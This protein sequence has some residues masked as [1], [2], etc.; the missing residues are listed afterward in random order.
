MSQ[1]NSLHTQLTNTSCLLGQTGPRV[2]RRD[3]FN[4]SV[5]L[6]PRGSHSGA[7][8]P[9][10]GPTTLNSLV[11]WNC[12]RKCS[13]HPNILM[14][15]TLSCAIE[16]QLDTEGVNSTRSARKLDVLVPSF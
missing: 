15:S 9:L 11:G 10:W 7:S 2:S 6:G 12:W 14:G 13:D 1:G 4:L 5:A 3:Q 8:Q 16:T